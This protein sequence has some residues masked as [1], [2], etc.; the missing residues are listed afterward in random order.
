ML[1]EQRLAIEAVDAHTVGDFD[2]VELGFLREYFI[3]VRFEEGVRLEDFRADAARNLEGY[4][5]ASVSSC[6]HSV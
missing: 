4:K 5:S 1:P 2:E 3:D 6:D